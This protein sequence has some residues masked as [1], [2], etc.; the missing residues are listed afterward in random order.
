MSENSGSYL[1]DVFFTTFLYGSVFP[2]LL[3]EALLKIFTTPVSLKLKASCNRGFEIFIKT[4]KKTLSSKKKFSLFFIT[5]AEFLL[6]I[7]DGK[8]VTWFWCYLLP[9]ISK[10]SLGLTT[11]FE[12]PFWTVLDK[13]CR[14]DMLLKHT[15]IQLQLLS[16]CTNRNQ[17]QPSDHDTVAMLSQCQVSDRTVD[18]V[19]D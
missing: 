6:I 14:P 7:L 2:K 12:G 1:K 4:G 17:M 5:V 3:V 10:E 18:M 15:K 9:F 11:N 13:T 8:S 16:I 19:P